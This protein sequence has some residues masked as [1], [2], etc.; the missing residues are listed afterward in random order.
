MRAD[1]KQLA[2]LNIMKDLLSRLHYT[3]K[4]KRLLRPDPRI[5][6]TYAASDLENGLFAP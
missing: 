4:D 1:D 5:V 2:R 3:G 6:L